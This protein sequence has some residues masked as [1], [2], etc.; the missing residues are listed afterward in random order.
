MNIEEL[1]EY[2]LQKPAVT[3]SLPFG[4]DTLVYKVGGK[5]FILAG[6]TPGDSFN[7][8]CDPELAIE[9]REKF[10]E[11]TPGYHMNKAHWNT[12]YMS[13]S[14]NSKQLRDMIDH[15]YDLV[16]KSLPKK[17]QADIAAGNY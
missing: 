16:L 8:K 10:T 13:G 11:V 2:C 7:A 9:L 6:I 5:M 4:D 12:I 15:S 17:L 3:E 14:L 1:R